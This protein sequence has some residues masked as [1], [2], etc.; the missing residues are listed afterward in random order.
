MAAVALVGN[1]IASGGGP[2]SGCKL[3]SYIRN[4]TTRSPL[5]S[6]VGLATPTTHPYV[7]DADGRLS[8]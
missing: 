5:Y 8:F 4:T 3:N 6:E 7:G 1:M 2:A